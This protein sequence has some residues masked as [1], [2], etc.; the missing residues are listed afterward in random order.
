MWNS[1]YV[2]NLHVRVRVIVRLVAPIAKIVTSVASPIRAKR[3]EVAQFWQTGIFAVPRLL[4]A[5]FII[6]KH[7]VF[8]GG[9]SA[10]YA[11]VNATAITNIL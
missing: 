8:Y 2:P 9:N 3:R 5:L 7:L 6:M 10:K 11:F 1:F 4:P